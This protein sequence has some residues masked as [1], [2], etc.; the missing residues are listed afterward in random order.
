MLQDKI[1][2]CLVTGATKAKGVMILLDILKKD[3]AKPILIPTPA[4]I[5]MIDWD[6][7]CHDIPT[8]HKSDCDKIPEE[9]IVIVAPCTFN[10]FSKIAHGI[11]DNHP[12]SILHAAIGKGKRIVIAPAMGE[13]YWNHPIMSQNCKIVTEF[14]VEIV[15]PEHI[16]SANGNLEKIT[17]APWEKIFDNICYPYQKIRYQNAQIILDIETIVNANYPE[18][19]VLGKKMQE[20]HYT[21]AAAG[22]LAKRVPDG[23]LV[24]RSGSLIGNLSRNDLVFISDWKNRIVSWS[25][26]GAPSS[27]TP[28]ILEI[29]DAFPDINTIVH[30]HCRDI[31]YSPKMVKYH[32]SEHLRYGYW[33]DFFKIAPTLK[34]HHC[35]IMKLHGEIVIANDF[36]K[37]LNRYAK[38]YEETL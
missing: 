22:F 37:A 33:R 10:T 29:F 9:D 5:S 2:Y 11:A 20:D 6:S 21:N 3:G 4:A 1:V 35:G 38:M 32:S 31:T 14:G 12:M 16:Y 15:W 19:S 34:T 36:N 17:M 27:E 8:R 13:Q 25:G 18:F 30:G 23:I 26:R 24:T 28:L 7:I